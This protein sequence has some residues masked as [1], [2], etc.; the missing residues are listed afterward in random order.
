MAEPKNTVTFRRELPPLESK[1][2]NI[3]ELEKQ[4]NYMQQTLET[5]IYLLKKRIT[6]L[7][8]GP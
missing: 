3:K 1:D 8:T 5:T 4:L 2:P 7:E 6:D